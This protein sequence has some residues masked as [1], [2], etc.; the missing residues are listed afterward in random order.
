MK[1]TILTVML[2]ALGSMTLSS[3]RKEGCTDIDAT[4]FNEEADKDDGSCNYSEN[5]IIWQDE[6]TALTAVNLGITKYY[7]FIDGSMVGS[8]NASIYC[9]LIEP[10]SDGTGGLY[11]KLIDFGNSRSKSLTL[12]VKNQDLA[13]VANYSISMEAGLY[14]KFKLY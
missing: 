2:F 4:N 10:L 3:C 9:N 8:A 13:I 6:S 14:K 1:K 11:T 5:L 7:F 12:T